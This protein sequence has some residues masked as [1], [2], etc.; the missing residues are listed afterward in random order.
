M[1]SMVIG[2]NPT[3]VIGSDKFQPAL[4]IMID[5]YAK[6]NP[7][8][9]KMLPVET[10][11]PELLVEMG[12]SSSGTTHTK[13]I[14]DLSMI[15]FYNLL[16]TGEYTVKGKHNNTKQ[17][18]QCHFLQKDEVWSRTNSFCLLTVPPLSLTTTKNGWKGVCVHR[19]TNGHNFYCP[20]RALGRHYVHLRKHGALVCE[21]RVL[22][23]MVYLLVYK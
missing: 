19:E 17:T 18:V 3:K 23:L 12:Y 8:T 21:L 15:A 5:G 14:R 9:R 2:N 22:K 16:H 1:I 10:D 11:V 20:I 7:P 6:D 13:A 4:Q